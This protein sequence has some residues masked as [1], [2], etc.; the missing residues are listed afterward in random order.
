VDE[1]TLF[2]DALNRER[3]STLADGIARASSGFERDRFLEACLDG[4]DRLG[5]G[6]RADRIEQNLERFLPDDFARAVDILVASLGPEPEVGELTGF[7]G[8]HIMP[9]TM[10]IARRGLDDPDRSLGALYE[11]TKRFSAEGDIRPFL[12]RYPEKTLAV[13]RRLCDASPRS[14][15]AR[16]FP[17]RADC[18]RFNGIRLR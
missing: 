8:F 4:L 18:R 17:L 6:E 2:R 1:R 10:C 7:D 3:I 5:F 11:M 16:A 15:R 12:K 14:E 13:L 9:M